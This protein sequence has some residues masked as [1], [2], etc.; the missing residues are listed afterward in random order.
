[1]KNNEKQ[2]YGDHCVTAE[3]KTNVR[4]VE[5]VE[6]FKVER[7]FDQLITNKFR[8]RRKVGIINSMLVLFHISSINYH[9]KQ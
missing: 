9:Y 6:T 2:E 8:S 3:N 7:V 1:M 5:S 4:Q